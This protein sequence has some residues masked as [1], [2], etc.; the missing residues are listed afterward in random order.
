[1]EERIIEEKEKK[2][3]K[4]RGGKVKVI[5]ALC[6]IALII[7]ALFFDLGGLGSQLG[8]PTFGPTEVTQPDSSPQPDIQE[9][10]DIQEEPDIPEEPTEPVTVDEQEVPFSLVIRVAGDAIFHGDDPV[11]IDQ[12]QSILDEH[13]D[14]GVMWEL[15]DEQ[16]ILAVYEE[17]RILLMEQG[18]AF[19]ET[20]G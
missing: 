4:K 10:P 2:K 7:G 17:V 20:A 13:D 3:K 15:R 12:L 6:I 11:T 8:L 16:A 1:M 5:A 19:T 14:P 18:A 9:G